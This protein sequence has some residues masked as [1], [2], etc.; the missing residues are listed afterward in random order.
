M[1]NWIT[2]PMRDPDPEQESFLRSKEGFMGHPTAPGPRDPYVLR[3]GL[4]TTRDG[5]PGIPR[6]HPGTHIPGLPGTSP[7]GPMQPGITY[8]GDPTDNE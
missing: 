5:V 7:A 4:P 1:A 6:L 8:D 2:G 3:R